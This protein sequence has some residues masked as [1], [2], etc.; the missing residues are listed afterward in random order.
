M[1]DRT[2]SHAT[3]I[4][5]ATETLERVVGGMNI[6]GQPLSTNIADTRGGWEMEGG[7]LTGP[8]LGFGLGPGVCFGATG[9]TFGP[10]GTL[11]GA[12]LTG[13]GLGI[14]LGS[15]GGTGGMNGTGTGV[16]EIGAG[17]GEGG[18]GEGGCGEGGCSA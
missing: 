16:G 2:T 8:G 12:G 15:C 18:F 14:G 11:D 1:S 9:D 4:E 13:E 6:E 3:L 5:L 17:L 10:G 7:G